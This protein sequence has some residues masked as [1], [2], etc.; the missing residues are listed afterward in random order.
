MQKISHFHVSQFDKNN[1][2]VASINSWHF[3]SRH[4]PV[5]LMLNCRPFAPWTALPS[6]TWATWANP[7]SQF[8]G[9]VPQCHR[10]FIVLGSYS[11]H[12]VV[13]HTCW[14]KNGVGLVQGSCWY[15]WIY[16]QRLSV[17]KRQEVL[18]QLKKT[19][20]STNTENWPQHAT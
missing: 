3:W 17:V 2:G 4:S 16:I 11:S 13:I 19:G 20:M 5:S 10:R 14:K 18:I 6:R 12:T 8:A 9:R 15:V 1:R 7:G